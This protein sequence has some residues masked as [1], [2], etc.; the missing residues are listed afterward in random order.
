MLAAL[1]ESDSFLWCSQR[2]EDFRL[3]G[4]EA[5]L[6]LGERT[7]ADVPTLPADEQGILSLA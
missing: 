2:D 1:E 4:R 3:E 5:R 6:G 7:R